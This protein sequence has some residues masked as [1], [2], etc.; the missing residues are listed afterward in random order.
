MARFKEYFSSKFIKSK[1]AL[2]N[3]IASD[4]SDGKTWDLKIN[5]LEDYDNLGLAT[6]Y[7]R[8]YKTEMQSGVYNDFFGELFSEKKYAEKWGDYEFI[9]DKKT[10]KVRRPGEKHFNTI[11]YLVPLTMAGK[12]KSTINPYSIASI[13]YDEFAP[14]DGR[15]LPNEAEL[16]LELW[17]TVD[18]DRNSIQLFIT[19]NRIDPFNPI[20]AY[21][22]I[23]VRIGEKNKLNTYKNGTFAVQVYSSKEHRIERK[24]SK[25]NDLI[26]GTNYENYE[27]GGILRQ[28]NLKQAKRDGMNFWCR[29]ATLLGE[30]TLWYQGDK[31]LVSEYRRQDGFILTDEIRNYENGTQEFSVKSSN[32]ANTIRSAWRNGLFMFETDKAYYIFQDILRMVNV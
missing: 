18:R 12:L 22:N 14:L 1:G 31:I 23:D 29:F 21:F 28:F 9:G 24:A 17:K 7:V 11:V 10:I 13:R 3:Y 4:R 26:S 8:R 32:F 30:G 15:Y 27:Y 5:A 16:L 2:F 19:G 25:F 6:I 20:C